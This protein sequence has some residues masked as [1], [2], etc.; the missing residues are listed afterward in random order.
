MKDTKYLILRDHYEACFKEHGDSHKGM[1]WPVV[2]D[3][4][5][6]YRIMSE[7]RKYSGLGNDNVGSQTLLDFGCGVSHLY[8][9]I[10]EHGAEEFSRY[11][12]VD[13]SQ[14][15]IDVSVR[16]YPLNEYICAD[17]LKDTQLIPR[18]DFV[19][20]NGVFTEKLTMSFDEMWLWVRRMMDCLFDKSEV[21]LACNFMSKNVDWERDDLFHLPLGLLVDYLSEN[22]SKNFVVRSDY[23]LYEYTLYL[24]R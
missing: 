11:I 19:V 10:E 24:Y 4:I 15:F 8:E 3:A 20:A 13:I 9:Y 7:V 18:C 17:I 16:K 6:R 12:G 14:E 23:G 2:E 5:T 1:D 21:G 22:L